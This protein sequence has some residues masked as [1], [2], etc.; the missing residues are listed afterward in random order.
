MFCF[1]VDVDGMKRAAGMFYGVFDVYNG[2]MCV[3]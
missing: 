2:V 3:A 1:D